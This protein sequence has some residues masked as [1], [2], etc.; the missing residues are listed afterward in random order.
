M[1]LQAGM[2]FTRGAF[3][4]PI[5]VRKERVKRERQA[6]RADAI[7]R[8]N[9]RKR[10]AR[11]LG[12]KLDSIEASVTRD[13]QVAFAPDDPAFDQLKAKKYNW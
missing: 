12:K 7:E 2:C 9:R 3:F 1:K 5:S 13:A 10:D 4:E 8:D 11:A 6:A